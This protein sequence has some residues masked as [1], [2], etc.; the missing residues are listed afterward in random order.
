MILLLIKF[1]NEEIAI[2]L[3]LQEARKR[4]YARIQWES[5]QNHCRRSS[6]ENQRFRRTHQISV[7]RQHKAICFEPNLLNISCNQFHHEF[8]SALFL[9]QIRWKKWLSFWINVW[10]KSEANID[11]YLLKKMI[12]SSSMK[13][14]DCDMKQYWAKSSDSLNDCVKQTKSIW[15]SWM[16]TNYSVSLQERSHLMMWFWCCFRFNSDLWNF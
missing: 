8:D 13:W 9:N 14:T 11:S 3:W 15:K 2:Q 10:K 1:Y 6:E 12:S 5:E 16:K 7:E 4:L